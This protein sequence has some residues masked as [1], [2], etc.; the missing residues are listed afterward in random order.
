MSNDGLSDSDLIRDLARTVRDGFASLRVDMDLL[1]E[2]GRRLNQR[3]TRLEERLDAVEGRITRN[4]ERVREPSRHD[5]EL[6]SELAKERE[7]REALAREVS[8][9]ASDV[10]ATKAMAMEIKDVL[11]DQVAGFFRR[12]PQVTAS[13]VTLIT[14]AIGAATAWIAARG[15]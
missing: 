8:A 3:M 7:S 13:I 15:H 1:L 14:T 5:L 10:A 12:H 11:V 4:S 6:Q 9:L 2:D